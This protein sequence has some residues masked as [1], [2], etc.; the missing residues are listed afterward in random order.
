MIKKT[1]LILLFLFVLNTFAQPLTFRKTYGFYSAFNQANAVLVDEQGNIYVAGATAGFGAQEGDCWFFKTD[2]FG[3]VIWNKVYGGLGADIAVSICKAYDGGFL[4]CGHSNS[5]S[6]GDYDILVIKVDDDGNEIWRISYGGADWDLA[7]RI[8]A[9]GDNEYAIVGTTYSFGSGNADVWLLKIDNEG[10][11]LW[12][13]T[14]G[15][16]ADEEGNGI[17]ITNDN[18]L[19]VVS[20]FLTQDN[21]EDIFIAKLD[22]DGDIIFEQLYGGAGNQRGSDVSS[23]SENGFAVGGIIENIPGL[24]E[25]YPIN[26]DENGDFVFAQFGLGGFFSP[27]SRIVH[28]NNDRHLIIFTQNVDGNNVGSVWRTFPGFFNDCS[29]SFNDVY[30]YS[31]NDITYDE[32]EFMILVGNT[33]FQT[34][35]QTAAY[36]AKFD[37]NCFS[38][39]NI[40]VSAKEI[41]QETNMQIF[42]NPAI[43]KLTVVSSTPLINQNLN[44]FL[45]DLCGRRF[46]LEYIQTDANQIQLK[47][48]RVKIASGLYSLQIVSSNKVIHH[49]IILK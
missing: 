21:G 41:E 3:E 39:G 5:F 14:F 20:T 23:N 46:E 16:A 8:I 42:P 38:E 29:F 7:K 4:L 15:T 24:F 25:Y 36:I 19:I 45:S 30:P 28:L 10:A 33:E 43:D 31:A 26:F 27:I 22:L 9:T 49:Q 40:Q 1:L 11:L 6:N 13:K 48:D 44:I 32:S 35:G 37:N 47:F 2:M 17:C 12:D 34:P 18:H